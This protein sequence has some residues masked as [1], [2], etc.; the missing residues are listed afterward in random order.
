[1]WV[2]AVTVLILTLNGL[3]WYAR[4]SGGVWLGASALLFGVWL[5]L[6]LWANQRDHARGKSSQAHAASP[7]PITPPD[8]VG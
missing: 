7:A 6:F 8:Y 2:T 4:P 3:L 1:M 5:A